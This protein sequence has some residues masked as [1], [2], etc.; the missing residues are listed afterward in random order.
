MRSHQLDPHEPVYLQNFATTVIYFAKTPAEL[1]HYRATDFRQG[2]RSLYA[3]AETFADEFSA[4]HRSCAKLLRIKP[5]RTEDALR[6]WTNALSI[7]HDEIER[8]GVY[9]HLARFKLNA[10]LFAEAHAHLNDVTNEN[11]GDLKKL[12]ARNL[13]E[14]ERSRSRPM[15]P[16]QPPVRLKGQPT[17][18]P[19]SRQPIFRPKNKPMSA[20]WERLQS[21]GHLGGQVPSK[22]NESAANPSL[23]GSQR[24]LQPP[25]N[26]MVGKLLKISQIK[27]LVL[28]L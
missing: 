9:L 26:L 2:A 22:V 25:C 18:L 13:A 7:A 1:S 24:H 28:R 4:R 21:E 12:L 8:E 27:H 15:P 14:R 10:G 17:L 23:H 16:R 19:R 6:S 11:Y 20:G 5:V 3:G